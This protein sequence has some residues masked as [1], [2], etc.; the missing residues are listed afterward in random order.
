MSFT[1]IIELGNDAL[2]ELHS[3]YRNKCQTF[4]SNS[5]AT[6]FDSLGA[7]LLY[8]WRKDIIGKMYKF[9]HFQQKLEYFTIFHYND[10]RVIM[11][12]I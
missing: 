8:L 7:R 11:I 3:S 1:F 12:R 9:V 10:Y 2:P 4:L 6:D 5:P